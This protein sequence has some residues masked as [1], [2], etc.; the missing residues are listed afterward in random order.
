MCQLCDETVTDPVERMT[1][2]DQNHFPASNG[3]LSID[4]YASAAIK[5]G[6]LPRALELAK[7][8]KSEGVVFCAEGWNT[9]FRMKV[10]E[11]CLTLVKEF[12][13]DNDLVII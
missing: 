9:P 8:L 4:L 13:R 2:M 5:E 11:Q 7:L 10:P 1:F 12:F 6:S 3:N